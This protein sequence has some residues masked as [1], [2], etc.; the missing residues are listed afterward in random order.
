[1]FPL[2]DSNE[3][4]VPCVLKVKY[5]W[6]S[7]RLSKIAAGQRSQLLQTGTFLDA[8]IIAWI[9]RIELVIFRPIT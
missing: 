4:S 9:T 7:V 3:S 5:T 1:M 8:Y 2:L 6:K